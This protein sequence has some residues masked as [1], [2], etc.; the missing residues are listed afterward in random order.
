MTPEQI[1]EGI[2]ATRF[3]ATHPSSAFYQNCKT[4]IVDGIERAL[5][6]HGIV[7]DQN[8]G[9]RI[10]VARRWS[11]YHIGDADWANGILAAYRD[12]EGTARELVEEITPNSG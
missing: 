7:G 10:R 4:S 8:R 6:Q 5:A 2:L 12:P 9:D 3:P 1:A 11:E